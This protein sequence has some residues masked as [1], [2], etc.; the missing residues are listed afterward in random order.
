M[1]SNEISRR[2]HAEGLPDACIDYHFRGSAGQEFQGHSRPGASNLR[3]RAKRTITLVRASVG[4]AWWCCPTARPPSIRTRISSSVTS[5]FT[6]PLPASYIKGWAGERFA[7]RNSGAKLVVEGLGDHGCEYMT[8]GLVVVL[9]ETGKNFGAGMSGG[10]AFVHD[11][12]DTFKQRLNTE[13]VDAEEL[14]Q[15]DRG[16]VRVMVENILP[17]RIPVRL[18]R[19]WRGGRRWLR[20]EGDAARL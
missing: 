2:Y 4:P 12:T 5:L 17:I 3:W 8:G 14:N 10:M 20:S 18:R 6:G 13:M 1:L 9:G 19:C 16:L 15:I 7:V 11:P